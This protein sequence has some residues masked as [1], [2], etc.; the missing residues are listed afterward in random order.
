MVRYFGGVKLG[1]WGL[2][3]AYKAAAENALNHAVILER[4]VTECFELIYD[5]DGDARSYAAC[6]GI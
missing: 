5:Y 2:I 3:T 1:V 6:E 4:E